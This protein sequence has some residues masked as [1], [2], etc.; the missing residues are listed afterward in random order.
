[1]A[2]VKRGVTTRKRHKK[3]LA[4]AKG[5]RMTRSR[6]YKVAREAV[7]HAGEYAYSG[8]KHRKRAMRRLWIQRVNAALI[9]LNLKYSNFMHLLKEKQIQLDRKILATIA[10]DETFFAAL[11]KKIQSI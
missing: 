6:L 2:R 8:R 4:Q 1:M 10:Q 7:L 9:P 11:V 5:Y 3:L